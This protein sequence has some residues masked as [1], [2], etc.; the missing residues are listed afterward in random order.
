M[1]TERQDFKSNKAKK[2]RVLKKEPHRNKKIFKR[3]TVKEELYQTNKIF[4]CT[5]MTRILD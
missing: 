3:K 2:Q 5:V 4:F 1:W